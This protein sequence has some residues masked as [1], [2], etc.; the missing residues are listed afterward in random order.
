[1]AVEEV[2][3]RSGK[4]NSWEFPGPKRF[5]SILIYLDIGVSK[6][7]FRR[8]ITIKRGEYSLKER[9]RRIWPKVCLCSVS[10]PY[11]TPTYSTAR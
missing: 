5:L 3:L 11:S 8:L 4:D 1:M 9:M 2:K 6:R 7:H 10:L